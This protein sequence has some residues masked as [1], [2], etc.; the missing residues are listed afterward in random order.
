MGTKKL[1]VMIKG[2]GDR[3]KWTL[4][5]KSVII[6][7]ASV[8]QKV[9]WPRKMHHDLLKICPFTFIFK[10]TTDILK[11]NHDKRVADLDHKKPPPKLKSQNPNF[12]DSTPLNRSKIVDLVFSLTLSKNH[13]QIRLSHGYYRNLKAISKTLSLNQMIRC[14]P[15]P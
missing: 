12:L 5:L 1:R 3:Q 6:K 14:A 2:D 4:I 9:P 15:L 7:S 13:L 10:I 11:V 8:Y